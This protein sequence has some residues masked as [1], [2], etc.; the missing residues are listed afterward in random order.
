MTDLKVPANE[1]M[2]S[3]VLDSIADPIVAFD[4][5]WR[6]TFVNR[7]AAEILGKSPDEMI[8]RCIW[9]LF[10][11][12][13]VCGFQEACRRAW[14]EGVPVTFERRSNLLGGWVES[15]I[16]PFENGAV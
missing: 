9:D 7:S 1:H 16:Y 11:E 15:R 8:G 3:D 4:K 10:P 12:D 5:Q 2:V 13:R 14:R 6:Y